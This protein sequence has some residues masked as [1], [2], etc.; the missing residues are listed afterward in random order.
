[1]KGTDFPCQSAEAFIRRFPAYHCRTTPQLA[2]AVQ[3]QL[4][5]AGALSGWQYG[6]IQS[7]SPIA[8]AEDAKDQLF[9]SEIE[10]IRA[11]A[12]AS[13]VAS[14]S[15][16]RREADGNVGTPGKGGAAPGVIDEAKELVAT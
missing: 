1:M 7:V 3:I 14:G 9:D 4:M 5:L 15:G 13:D 2:P 10:G 16:V 12:A 11:A 6:L 8:E